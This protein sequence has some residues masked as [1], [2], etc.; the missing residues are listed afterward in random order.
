M[1][2]ETTT[3]DVTFFKL[4]CQVEQHTGKTV[5][6]PARSRQTNDRCFAFI[7]STDNPD[8]GWKAVDGTRASSPRQEVLMDKDW[9]GA[10][11][12]SAVSGPMTVALISPV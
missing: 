5:R 1:W 9:P 8:V 12:A 10:S 4:R 7:A 3:D 6:K 2:I 11:G